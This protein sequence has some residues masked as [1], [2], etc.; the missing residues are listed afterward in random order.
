LLAR[1]A[2]F[3][4]TTGLEHA[5]SDAAGTDGFSENEF[6]YVLDDPSGRMP[7]LIAAR[8]GLRR[9]DVLQGY[10]D[11]NTRVRR[12]VD[13]DDGATSYVFSFKRKAARSGKVRE[14]EREIDRETFEDLFAECA[15]SLR[16]LR[17]AFEEEGVHWDVDVLLTRKGR[18][19]FVKA[20]AEVGPEVTEA[21][22]PCATLAPFVVAIPGKRKGFSSR[23]LADED[24]ARPLLKGILEA[25]A[26]RERRSGLRLAA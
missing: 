17:Y 16:K 14:I 1:A 9:L 20:E 6:N 19:Y 13:L 18:P 25:N 24:Y 11:D 3:R 8:P 22:E 15:V 10:V 12:F 5:M 26:K 2:T 23:R 21:P 7:A 4:A